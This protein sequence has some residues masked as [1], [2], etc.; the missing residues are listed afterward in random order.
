MA[1]L[2]DWTKPTYRTESL[3]PTVK[4]RIA[5]EQKIAR[6][7]VTALLACGY[8]L[9]VYDGEEVTVERSTDKTAICNA[10]YTTDEDYLFVFRAGESSRIG[11]VRFVYGNDG[12]DVICDYTTNLDSPMESVMQFAEKFCN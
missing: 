9:S 1:T 2:R 10:M 5:V 7:T 11:W 12:W 8:S 3:P 4:A 6:H